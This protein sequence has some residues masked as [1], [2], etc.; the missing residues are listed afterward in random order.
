[1][2]V[3]LF[4]GGLGTRIREY[5]EASQKP[6]IP[7]GHQPIL[8]H[9]M[10]YYSRTGTAISCCASATRPTSSRTISCTYR[11]PS[12]CVV[13]QFG[14]KIEIIGEQ[15]PDWRLT[16][17]DTGVW[18]NIGQRLVAVKEHVEGRGDLPGQ[19]QRRS[20]RRAAA[21]DDRFLQ[22]QRQTGLLH[23][24]TP[25]VQFP[26]GRIR[27]QN[28]MVRADPGETAES[29][30]WINGGYFIFR[31]EIFD[32][33]QDGEELVLQPF[34]RLIK[35][36]NLVAFKYEGFWRSMDTLQDRQVLEEMVEK[37]EMPWPPDTSSSQT[38]RICTC[39]P[40][41]PR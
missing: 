20:H 41:R 30:L 6:M 27:R 2:K 34:N 19:L 26:S 10:Q 29:E 12:D 28:G 13:S 40:S 21:G 31:N 22:G 1:M 18:R 8:W 33:M 39:C 16:M 25:A 11:P 32:Y 14:K 4:C 24:G 3:V 37:G 38:L 15:Q 7:V 36:N 23:R 17:I 35:D 5:S 9:V